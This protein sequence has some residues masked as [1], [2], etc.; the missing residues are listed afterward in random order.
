MTLRRPALA[1][2]TLD[3]TGGGVAVV[4]RMMWR[5]LED[6]FGAQ[7]RLVT[8]FDHANRP[9][10]LA[11]NLRF[12]ARL[13][14][15][16]TLGGSDR[17]LFSHLNLARAQHVIPERLWKPY[18][19]FLHGIEA[20][21]GVTPAEHRM[22]RGARAVIANSAFTATRVMARHPE[23]G[24]VHVCP[25]ALEA[26]P[27][28][29]AGDPELQV[30]PHA[31]LVVGRM[32]ASE[33]YKGH[34]QLLA[35]WPRV[36][37]AIPDAEL[38]VVGDG[39]DRARLQTE[40]RATGAGESVRFRGFV[41][42]DQ[43][44]GLYRRAALFALPSRGEGFGLVYLEAMARGVACIGSTHD[45]AGEVIDDGVTG[46]LV[47]QEPGALADALVR[48]LSDAALRQR[49]GEAG[50]TRVRACFSFERF[51]VRLTELLTDDTLRSRA[52]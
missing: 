30:G 12:G 27:P 33:R 5:T 44:D 31:V 34:D 36:R 52:R 39:D 37:A 3:H 4:A 2:I 1:A 41:T 35:A 6:R 25:L 17:L 46:C 42:P 49:M 15:T 29:V 50:R 38:I 45:A 13:A 16:Q 23:L 28:A 9:S 21:N 22:L 47:A 11:E 26:E 14:L 7:A 40:A 10:T 51:S 43:L 32:S 48:L 18:D 24:P 8:I 19:V 20:W